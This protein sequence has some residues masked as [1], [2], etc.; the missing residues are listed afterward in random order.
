MITAVLVDDMRPALR[1]LEFLSKK[2]PEISITGMYTDPLEV[3]EK[4]GELNVQVVFLDINMPQLKGIDAASRI[5][6][7]SP[8]TD[9]V[10]VTAYDQYAVEAFEVHALDYL[11]KPVAEERLEK[12]V[13]RLRK[14]F[15]KAREKHSL[16]LKI[17]CF[18]QFQMG[19]EGREPI[20]WR[21]EKARELF[22]YLLENHSRSITRDE[23]LDKLWPEIDPDKAVK[24][25]YNGI[26]YIRKALEGYGVSRDIISIN[27]NYNLIL[28]A[29][30]WDV[31]RFC[32]FFAKDKEVRLEVLEEMEVLYNGDYLEKELYSWSDYERERLL[33]LYEQGIIELSKRY[34]EEERYERAK[35][36]LLKAY[37]K[38]P[39]SE[40]IT[41]LL[42]QLY[43]KTGDKVNAVRHFNA[44]SS[45]LEK[46]LGIMPDERLKELLKMI[47]AV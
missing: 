42:L 22:A 20:K 27:N 44:Y 1:E 3:I 38:N 6:D 30:E 4:I 32:R 31:E 41:V 33:K 12:T 47:K 36:S 39:Y 2:Y 13:A 29:V 21:T 18:Q 11:L 15:S 25:L 35:D 24:H 16:K 34:I 19:W 10:F 23:L 17:Q 26:Y 14:K 9:I 37:S 8:E 7:S 45:L 28:G 5:L 40:D 43:R 46:E